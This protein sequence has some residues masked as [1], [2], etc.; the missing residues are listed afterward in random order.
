VTTTGPL[1][2][3]PDAGQHDERNDHDDTTAAAATSPI[4]PATAAVSAAAVGTDGAADAAGPFGPLRPL[5]SVLRFRWLV[6]FLLPVSVLSLLAARTPT[7]DVWAWMVWGREVAH[8]DLD[9]TTGPMWKPLPIAVAALFSP[10]GDAVPA[11]WLVIARVGGLLAVA[12]AARLAYRISGPFAAAGAAASLLTVHLWL[13]YLLPYGMSEPMLAAFI[14]WAVDRH[15]DGR[16]T[17]AFWLLIGAS[18]LRPE[19]WPFLGLYT[20]WLLRRRELRWKAAAGGLA[21]IPL[22]WFLPQW[23]GSGNPFRLGQGQVAPNGPLD[24]DHPGLAALTQVPADLLLWVRIGAVAGIAWAV[25]VRDRL[26]L[27]LTAGGLAWAALVAVMAELGTSSGVSRYMVT[28]EAVAAVLAGV[29]WVEGARLVRGWLARAAARRGLGLPTGIGAVLPGVAA[30]AVAV[31]S[32]LTFSD[33]LRPSL[34]EAHYQ[35]A[36]YTTLPKAIDAAGGKGAI[37]S[38]GGRPWVDP[39]QVTFTAWQLRMHISQIRSIA[40]PGGK[41]DT[42][43]GTML[44]TRNRLQDPV[45]PTTFFFLDWKVI[46]QASGGG[47]SWTIVT[48]CIDRD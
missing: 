18:L 27:V 45:Q 1:A 13:G 16:R 5:P 48:P 11:V 47:A 31:P 32:G 37:L 29:G 25:A 19:I 28:T 10:T 40:V 43:V 4:A 2:A 12:A 26:L 34:H 6:A 38:C 21:L 33:D 39:L 35:Q 41:I 8:L 36:L 7:Y 44:Q 20:L 15:L 9:T 46:G 30:L 17:Q 14:L 3:A 42:Y 24:Q 22:G 23:F